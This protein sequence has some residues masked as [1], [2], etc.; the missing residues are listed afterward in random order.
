MLFLIVR[1]R[2]ERL[3]G[4]RIYSSSFAPPPTHCPARGVG[5]QGWWLYSA[6]MKRDLGQVPMVPQPTSTISAHV[7]TPG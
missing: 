6:S 4:E 7:G 1:T 3:L 5:G 2:N